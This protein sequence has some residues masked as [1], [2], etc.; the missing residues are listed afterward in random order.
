M[1]KLIML[2]NQD[3]IGHRDSDE[4]ESHTIPAHGNL[5]GKNYYQ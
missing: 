3:H 1:I 2:N 5:R 4:P